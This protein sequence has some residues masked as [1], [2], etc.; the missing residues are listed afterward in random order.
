MAR[1]PGGEGREPKGQTQQAPAR[2]R[3]MAQNRQAEDVGIDEVA[4]RLGQ[5]RRAQQGVGRLQRLGADMLDAALVQSLRPRTGRMILSRAADEGQIDPR[6]SPVGGDGEV[7]AVGHQPI[8]EDGERIAGRS[9]LGPPRRPGVQIDRLGVARPGLE[10]QGPTA[11]AARLQVHHRPDPVAQRMFAEEGA[12]PVQVQF[13]GVGQEDDQPPIG[14]AARLDRPHR[15]QNGG[16]AAGVVG[17]PRRPRH[18]VVMG[19]QHH[20]RQARVPARQDADQIDGRDPLRGKAVPLH[21]PH[22]RRR[23]GAGLERR[24][25]A[26]FRHPAIEIGLDQGVVGRADR[27]GRPGRQP[28]VPHRPFGGKSGGRRVRRLGAR[29]LGGEHG[30]TQGRRQ[31]R[32]KQDQ[33]HAIHPPKSLARH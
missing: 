28:H 15:L 23:Q 26:Q 18:A 25:Q 10:H 33:P 9:A 6:Q 21:P 20:Q 2:L 31:S 13:L 12:R 5:G 7:G 30:Q 8:D 29:G 16:H 24:R 3:P 19:H 11:A 22:G 1:A 4:R 27:P 32:Q 14:R 17:R